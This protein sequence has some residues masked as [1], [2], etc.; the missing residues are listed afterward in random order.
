MKTDMIKSVELAY[1]F[2]WDV[3]YHGGGSVHDLSAR[4]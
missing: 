3:M 4:S 1:L 2:A